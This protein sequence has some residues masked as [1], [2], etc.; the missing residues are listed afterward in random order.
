M[1]KTIIVAA[2]GMALA[3][4]ACSKAER[5]DTTA[6]VQAAADKV[7]DEAKDAANSPELKKMG[8]EIKD[9]AGDAGKVLK[10]TAKGAAQGAREGAAKVEAESKDETHDAKK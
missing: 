8:A 4:S 9:A 7:G 6:D 3:L 10:E 2:A 1:H 5:Q